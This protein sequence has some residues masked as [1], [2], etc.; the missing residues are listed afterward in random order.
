MNNIISGYA[1]KFGEPLN[2]DDYTQTIIKHGAI[3]NT[4]LNNSDV[5]AVF[6][7]N[8]DNVMAR[9]HNGKGNLHLKVDNVGLKY[10]LKAIDTNLT[11]TLISYIDS[12]VIDSVTPTYTEDNDYTE[13]EKKNGKLIKIVG[14]IKKLN[15]ISFGFDTTQ[16]IP[17]R[18]IK[19]TNNTNMK[20]NILFKAIRQQIERKNFSDDVKEAIQR[21]KTINKQAVGQIALPTNELRNYYKTAGVTIPEIN[22]KPTTNVLRDNGATYL[23]GLSNDVKYPYISDNNVQFKANGF[24]N[25]KVTKLDSTTIAPKRIVAVVNYSMETIIAN[26]TDIQDAITQDLLNAIEQSFERAILSDAAETEDLPKGL[27]KGA[28]PITLAGY[29]DIIEMEYQASLKDMNNTIYLVSPSAAKKLKTMANGGEMV[30]KNGIINGRKVVE[31]NNVQ[32]GYVALL[33]PTKLIIANWGVIDIVV[34]DV[35]QKR[36]GVVRLIINTYCNAALKNPTQIVV[37]KI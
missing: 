22:I 11:D 35:T 6:N 33:D 34:D 16:P 7:K 8:M 13:W 1:F 2:N 4:V 18:K 37:G 23:N 3:T 12:G 24:D 25:S 14:K 27:F 19:K 30:M 32:D 29:T 21:A 20:E 26:N 5:F 10:E 36:T 17:K 28:T 31:S 15:T 9:Y